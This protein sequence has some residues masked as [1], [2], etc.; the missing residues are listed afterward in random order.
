MSE[1]RHPLDNVNIVSQDL[2][3]TPREVR[4]RSPL[5]EE[6]VDFVHESRE[7]VKRILSRSDHRLMVVVGPC[8]IHDLDAARE[9]ATRL[10]ALARELSDTLLLVMR[11]Y[12]E[13]PRTSIGWKGFIN[14]PYLDDSF[15]IDDGLC[16]AREFLVQLAEIGVPVGTEA[17]DPITP[18]YLSDLV[19]WVAIGARTTESQTHRDMASG[20]SAPVGFKNATDGNVEVAVNALRA[21]THPQHFLGVTIDGRC[22]V[23]HTRGNRYGHV[24]LRGGSA[25]PNYDSVSVAM[26]EEVLEKANIASNIVIDCSHGNSLKKPELQ[27]LVLKSVVDQIINGNR[28]IMGVMLESHLC[29]GRQDISGKGTDL[30]HGVSVTDACIGW[31]KTV[32]ILRDTRERLKDVLPSRPAPQLVP[33]PSRLGNAKQ[34]A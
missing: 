2:L 24:I 34:D 31:D 11:V 25:R 1:A 30:E 26:C 23:F 28:S 10:E 17:L 29:F 7:Q 16:Q 18:Q 27:P 3:P 6:L 22:A 8:S 5:S 4:D 32:E 20:L 33:P 19:S 21:V 12:F 13:K 14:D 15:K 9:Y